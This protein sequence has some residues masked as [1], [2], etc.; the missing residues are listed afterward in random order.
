MGCLHMSIVHTLSLVLL[1]AGPE[2]SDDAGWKQAAR[3]DGIT[4]FTRERE[5]GVREVK[6]IGLV[7][8]PPADVWR[9]VRDYANYDKTMPYTKG[10]KVLGTEDDGK[11]IYFYSAVDAPIVSKRDFTIKITDESKLDAEGKGYYLARWTVV[12]KGIPPK[13]DAVRLKVN[14]GYWKLEPR[15]EGK[16][17]FA[18]YYVFTDPGGSIPKFLVNKANNSAVPDVFRAIRKSVKK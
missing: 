13:D 9:A 17:T 10:S 3:D 16:Q 2:A 12:D 11:V 6:A 8:A 14:D 5:G 1:L 7:E 18:T 4:V 15:G